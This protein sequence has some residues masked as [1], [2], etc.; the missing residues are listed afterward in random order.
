M[1]RKRRWREEIREKV[2]MKREDDKKVEIR[3]KEVQ[4]R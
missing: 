2:K 4:I 3:E 1:E